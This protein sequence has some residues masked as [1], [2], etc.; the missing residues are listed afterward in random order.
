MQALLCVVAVLHAILSG[1]GG[2]QGGSMLLLLLLLHH[3]ERWGTLIHWG[4]RKQLRG[5]SRRAHRGASVILARR[6]GERPGGCGHVRPTRFVRTALSDAGG[7]GGGLVTGAGKGTLRWEYGG[8]RRSRGRRG[9]RGGRGDRGGDTRRRGRTGRG[10]AGGGRAGGAR[11]LGGER[12]KA[13]LEEPGGRQALGWRTG[14][15]VV[16]R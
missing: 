5:G 16:H 6:C 7:A 3:R 2:T 10:G 12:L 1:G 13:P 4:E 11:F 15:Q 9:V 8:K 14:Q